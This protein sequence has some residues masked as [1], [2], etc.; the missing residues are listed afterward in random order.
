MAQRLPLRYK[1]LTPAGYNAFIITANDT[2][3][4]E[5]RPKELHLPASQSD[6]DSRWALVGKYS[7]AAG[8]PVHLSNVIE[9]D[10]EH[11]TG[12]SGL[13]I[14][15]FQTS[16]LPSWVG[17]ELTNTFQ[18]YDDCRIHVLKATFG[19]VVQTVWFYRLPE[20]DLI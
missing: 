19:D 2:T 10:R 11:E 4:P 13:L 7:L 18:F 5:K 8:G 9:G 6:P 12:P 17:T 20:I 1:R 16:T 15:S 3:E 14:S